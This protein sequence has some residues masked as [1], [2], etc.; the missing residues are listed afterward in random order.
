MSK[1]G[2]IFACLFFVIFGFTGGLIVGYKIYFTPTTINAV[3]IGKVKGKDTS[4][5]D[6]DTQQ[7]SETSSK[8]GEKKK[9]IRKYRHEQ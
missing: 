8:T 2:K 1:T 9:K 6:L 3:E 7:N 5:I 4:T